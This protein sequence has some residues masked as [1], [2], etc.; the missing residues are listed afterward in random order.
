MTVWRSERKRAESEGKWAQAAE[1]HRRR[2]A[3]IRGDVGNI[4]FIVTI[5]SRRAARRADAPNALSG[6]AEAKRSGTEC[7]QHGGFYLSGSVGTERR[8]RISIP[9]RP[10]SGT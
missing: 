9:C 5:C 3:L 1:L 7:S 6:A 2:L 8:W 4:S 10:A